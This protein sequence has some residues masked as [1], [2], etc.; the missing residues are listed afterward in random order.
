MPA[1]ETLF[2]YLQGCILPVPI[3]ADFILLGKSAAEFPLALAIVLY[4]SS[5]GKAV[6]TDY[7]EL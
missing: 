7:L 6:N 5:L 2:I 4:W 1:G 3:A